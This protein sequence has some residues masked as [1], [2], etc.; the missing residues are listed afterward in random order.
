MTASTKSPRRRWPWLL[1]LLGPC[2]ALIP[3]AIDDAPPED[4]ELRAP[5]PDI[6]AEENAYAELRQ[7]AMERFIPPDD[8][9]RDA[10]NEWYPPLP[11]PRALFGAY[12]AKNDAV[13]DRVRAL[14]RD[15]RYQTP[16]GGA[17]DELASALGDL[18]LWLGYRARLR[19]LEG[20]SDEALEDALAVLALGARREDT[21]RGALEWLI[22]DLDRAGGVSALLDV[23][24]VSELD[25]RALAR[26]DARLAPFAADG[27]ESLAEAL[28]SDYGVALRESSARWDEPERF[29]KLME[30]KAARWLTGSPLQLFAFKPNRCR[31]ILAARTRRQVAYL[32]GGP[33]FAIVED[34]GFIG[35]LLTGNLI[36]RD[37]L[38]KENLGEDW[39]D[40]LK[41]RHA[42]SRLA[43][44]G[45]RTVVAL[46]RFRLAEGRLPGS[47][48]ELCP[49]FLKRVP[50]DHDGRPLRYRPGLEL[51]YSVGPDLRDDTAAGQEP[52]D[53]KDPVFSFKR[54]QS[55]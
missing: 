43:I 53:Y 18:L 29:T 3:L 46:R 12:L 13:F 45:L 52:E 48:S 2:L 54:K 27:L 50:E 41:G 16:A 22:G 39:V 11:Y 51:I 32:R 7:L 44:A 35:E 24:C 17:E 20:R 8:A 25:D 23:L 4:A 19:A 55:F 26:L 40:S 34:R 37:L 10:E 9:T 1:L 31:R 49:R 38:R 15:K 28:R 30:S 6:P 42:R 14:A 36:G 5:A 47:L 33:G 21:A